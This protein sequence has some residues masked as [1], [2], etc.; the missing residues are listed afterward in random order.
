[1]SILDTLITDRTAADVEALNAK[2]TYNAEDLNRVGEAMG[3]I[4]SRFQAMGYDINI[5]SRTDWGISD[6]PLQA[7][8]VQ[9]IADLKD[10]RNAVAVFPDTP[11][12]PNTMAYLNYYQANDIEQML[13]VLNETIDKIIGSWYYCAE[14]YS[15]E[16]T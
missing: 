1:M 8:M 5:Q 7:D 10:L 16:I 6:I 15:G 14:L 2:G 3:Y 4:A 11:Y 13:L 9:Y 12:V